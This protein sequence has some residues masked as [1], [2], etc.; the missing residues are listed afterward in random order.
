MCI[1]IGVLTSRYLIKQEGI[2]AGHG[3]YQLTVL[4]VV[5]LLISPLFTRRY[6]EST[7]HFFFLEG[8]IKPTRFAFLSTKLLTNWL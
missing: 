7:R 1:R 2:R 4:I 8:S 3:N 6:S 5:G